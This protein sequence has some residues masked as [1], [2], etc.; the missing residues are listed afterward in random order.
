[1]VG[2]VLIYTGI[3]RSAIRH[4]EIVLPRNEMEQLR[5]KL[6]LPGY[7]IWRWRKYKKQLKEEKAQ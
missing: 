4:L 3:D 7:A 6:I 2:G 5:W 1:M